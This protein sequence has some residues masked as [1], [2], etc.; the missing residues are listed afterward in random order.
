MGAET[1]AGA[2]VLTSSLDTA[3]K[4]A[5]EE[6]LGGDE[7]SAAPDSGSALAPESPDP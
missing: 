5:G 1:G 3:D 6:E 2:D 7:I 4:A